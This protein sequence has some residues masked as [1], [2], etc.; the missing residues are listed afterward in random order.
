[1][2]YSSGSQKKSIG[3]ILKETREAKGISL[4]TVHEITKIPMDVL[5]A[6]EEGYTVHTLA[7]FYLK[8]F[9]KMYAQYLE[10][11]FIDEPTELDQHEKEPVR[12]IQKLE[13]QSDP[14]LSKDRQRKIVMVA[15]V[16][17]L[18]FLLFRVGGCL[19]A[20]LK[21]P[22]PD[23]KV[24]LLAGE[25]TG[26]I[27]PIPKP[28]AKKNSAAPA[29]QNVSLPDTKTASSEVAAPAPVPVQ[30][31]KDPEVPQAA[32]SKPQE[33]KVRL[34]IRARKRGWLQ[35]KID[36]A[37]VLQSTIR[38]GAVE[39]WSA[40]KQIEISGRIIH[41]LEFELNGK[42]L[43]SLGRAD[44]TARRVIITKDGWSVKE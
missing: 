12:I 20:K 36:G 19:S 39:S 30:K 11:E 34:T 31:T 21:A 14:F 29:A 1:M 24:P 32:D 38:E 2:A 6:V 43:G 42:V 8:A 15:G 4:Y 33:D 44:R 17:F 3:G 28:K 5:K 18:L 16:L 9:I 25:E 35:V 7:P 40:D 26:E 22:A 13:I 27:V 41:E 37:L 10:V 23:S